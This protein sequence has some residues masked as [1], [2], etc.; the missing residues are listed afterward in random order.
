MIKNNFKSLF[1]AEAPK[2]DDLDSIIANINPTPE[3]SSAPEAAPA[4]AP[5]AA[6]PKA[7]EPTPA[8]PVAPSKPQTADAIFKKMAALEPDK[9]KSALQDVVKVIQA[10]GLKWVKDLMTKR[11]MVE[12]FAPND[13]MAF[14]NFKYNS[15]KTIRSAISKDKNLSAAWDKADRNAKNTIADFVVTNALKEF[16]KQKGQ[17]YWSNTPTEVDKPKD[18]T[19]QSSS[20]ETL[21]AQEK[22]PEE[23]KGVFDK[24]KTA[25]KDVKAGYQDPSAVASDIAKQLSPAD[26][27]KNGGGKIS[28][29]TSQDGVSQ[30]DSTEDDAEDTP[31]PPVANTPK[32][33]APKAPKVKKVKPTAP[34]APTPTPAASTP[35]VSPPTADPT[36]TAP[37]TVDPQKEAKKQQL[38]A[39]LKQDP[40][41]QKL[42]QKDLD[43]ISQGVTD[44]KKAQDIV[45]DLRTAYGGNY[46]VTDDIKH[47]IGKAIGEA[48]PGQPVEDTSKLTE[49]TKKLIYESFFM[50][51][52]ENPDVMSNNKEAAPNDLVMYYDAKDLPKLLKDPA[53]TKDK[54]KYNKLKVEIVSNDATDS[55]PE[56]QPAEVL[57]EHIA[58]LFYEED[59][60]VADTASEPSTDA[61]VETP[62]EPQQ[63]KQPEVKTENVPGDSVKIKFLEGKETGKMMVVKIKDLE[64]SKDLI[65]EFVKIGFYVGDLNAQKADQVFKNKL[66]EVSYN[67]KNK[68]PITTKV[69]PAQLKGILISPEFKAL[70]KGDFD[71]FEGNQEAIKAATDLVSKI[72][73]TNQSKQQNVKT[74]HIQKINLDNADKIAIANSVTHNKPITKAYATSSWK[75]KIQ[76]P[77]N[78]ASFDN[79]P[80]GLV[81]KVNYA[82]S[83]EWF[84]AAGAV[85][86]TIAGI[87]NGI[88][89]FA[90]FMK[91]NAGS[92]TSS[93]IK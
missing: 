20:S 32:A 22:P 61:P 1:E 54:V 68:K 16:D 49:S 45:N 58:S 37:V 53:K 40:V 81:S 56:V 19:G 13:P 43:S 12:D 52:A 72:N 88:S 11:K 51:E 25:Y 24:I 92:Q 83:F 27:I 78:A 5:V 66:A 21:S 7:Q 15:H 41:G 29:T 59:P 26:T 79:I 9:K 86:G 82:K 74:V 71:Q 50:A 46:T 36:P 14:K 76:D 89:K 8:A 67:A 55:T 91:N 84:K 93:N 87:A 10:N 42:A 34:V 90:G 18:A 38:S 57:K 35:P 85:L 75:G 44:G 70:L 65:V 31:T 48:N 3:A 33:K 17:T 64:L 73:E 23:K 63:P 2:P 6:T 4:A 47:I 28:A 62:E 80:A 39:T 77:K 60:V 69:D 30:D